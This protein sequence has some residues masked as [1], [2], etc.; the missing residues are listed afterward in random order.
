MSLAEV[1]RDQIAQVKQYLLERPKPALLLVGRPGTGKTF[2]LHKAAEE[3]RYR[4]WTIDPLTEDLDIVLKKMKARPLTPLIYHVT[5]AD[6]LSRSEVNELIECAKKSKA[7]LVLE[8][9]R[10]IEHGDLM[11]VQFYKLKAR[12]AVRIA[13]E[14]KI[15]VERI[16][17]YED[18][19]QVMLAQFGSSGYEEE[20]S[21]TKELERALK[22][23]DFKECGDTAL[24]LLLDSAHLN[25]FG[26][27]LY[28]FLKAIQTADKCKRP[29]PLMGFKVA[30]PTITSYFLEKLK[31]V[32][33]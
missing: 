10:S 5:S 8:S 18:V 25:F 28:F 20:T 2:A 27:D 14:L 3:L 16:K 4:V 7:P 13:E 19:R 31:L 12:D 26:R 24:F 30:K 1:L 33:Q 6:A 11:E 22:T 9:T 29:H 23:G 15:P 17:M 21:T 32:R